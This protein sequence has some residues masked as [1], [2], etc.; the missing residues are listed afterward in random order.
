[1][2]KINIT[3]PKRHKTERVTFKTFKIEFCN[4]LFS[5]Y[6]LWLIRSTLHDDPAAEVKERARDMS[7][8]HMN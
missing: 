1:M 2:R 3:T 7:L 8:G 4:R 5:L 6:E